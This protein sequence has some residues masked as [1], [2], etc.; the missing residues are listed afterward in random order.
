MEAVLWHGGEAEKQQQQVLK[1]DKQG[2][3][4]LNAFLKSL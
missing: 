1:L 3:A 4:E 2:R